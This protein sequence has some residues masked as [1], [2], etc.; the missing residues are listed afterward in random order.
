MFKTHQVEWNWLISTIH[1]IIKTVSVRC[2]RQQQKFKDVLGN[3]E[4]SPDCLLTPGG[5]RDVNGRR[6][7][8][9][10]IVPTPQELCPDPQRTSPSQ[11]LDPSHLRGKE[12]HMNETWTI[13]EEYRDAT[14]S[15]KLK[16]KKISYLQD[17]S[18]HIKNNAKREVKKLRFQRKLWEMHY[19]DILQRVRLKEYQFYL[20]AKLS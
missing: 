11:S 19:F 2:F 18:K 6:R 14:W 12:G 10:A 20:C 3:L 7:V 15:Q 8:V 13:W 17:I 9:D 4:R 16:L 1:F 5:C